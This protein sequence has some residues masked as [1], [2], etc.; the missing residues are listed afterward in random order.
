MTLNRFLCQQK[1][2]MKSLFIYFSVKRDQLFK[3][4]YIFVDVKILYLYDLSYH[5]VVTI[6]FFVEAKSLFLYY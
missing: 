1:V 2:N 4:N 3:S 5:Y 6:Y